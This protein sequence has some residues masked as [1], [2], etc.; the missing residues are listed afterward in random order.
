[1]SPSRLLH[2]AL[3]LLGALL[4]SCAQPEP[5]A[6]AE[7]QGQAVQ[8]PNAQTN[9][10]PSSRA[11]RDPAGELPLVAASALPR[12]G[13]RT[14]LLIRAG[15]P[16]PY[17]KDDSVFGNREGLLPRRERGHY[18]EYTVPTPGEDDRGARRIVCGGA[19]RSVTE[20]YYTA[21]HYRTFRR[22]RP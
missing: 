12:E 6:D 22:I 3:L 20:C 15:G 17:A 16:Y 1:M 7:A 13:R 5:G 11:G 2:S 10:A 9:P 4:V 14:L 19:R 8:A 18:R 21:D